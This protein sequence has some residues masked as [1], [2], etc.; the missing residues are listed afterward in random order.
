[1]EAYKQAIKIDP[2]Y[3]SA[4]YNLGNTYKD[5]SMYKEAV[6]SYKQAIRVNP[7]FVNAHLNLGTTYAYSLNDNSSAME[8]YRILQN[9]DPEKAKTLK[10]FISD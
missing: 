7:D 3:A 5:L 4:H 10:I 8:Q 2:D 1:M 9:L 6:E